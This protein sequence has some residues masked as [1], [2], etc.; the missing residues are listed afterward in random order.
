MIKLYTTKICPKCIIVKKKLNEKGINFIE[1]MDFEEM[2]NLNIKSVPVM[3]I[4][5]TLLN[6]NEIIEYLNKL[7]RT[8]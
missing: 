8:D 3:N 2:T 1:C 7:E 4:N 5:Y 6:F